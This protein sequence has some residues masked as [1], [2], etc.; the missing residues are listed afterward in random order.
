MVRLIF[1][2]DSTAAVSGQA[3]GSG[4]VMR[5][6][7]R[8]LV[9][10]MAVVA[11]VGASAFDCVA[12]PERKSSATGTFVNQSGA[13]VNGLVVKL[14]SPSIV[15]TDEKGY[16]GPFRNISGNDTA[17]ITLAN[18]A[19]PIADGDKIELTFAS[20]KKSLSI[21]TWWWIDAKGKRIGKKQNP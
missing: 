14:T 11:L 5:Q 4:G 17:Q 10:L 16:A 13:V 18:P 12:Q 19:E 8:G 1:N 7:V 9:V 20:N 15:V 3:G 2:R 21:T 6:W